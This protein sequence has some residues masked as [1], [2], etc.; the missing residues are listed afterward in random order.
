[1]KVF[2][3]IIILTNLFVQCLGQDD[4]ENINQIPITVFIDG[5]YIPY[6]STFNSYF[7]I[8]S[9][10]D[11]SVF[12]I[13]NG[14]IVLP[15]QSFSDSLLAIKLVWGGIVFNLDSINFGLFQRPYKTEWVFG[16]D[17]PPFNKRFNLYSGDKLAS[18]GR[19]IKAFKYWRIDPEGPY[20]SVTRFKFIYR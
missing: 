16:V 5:E 18:D 19:E 15:K 4:L 8:Y 20:K 2:L 6:D 11:T 7:S 9:V 17:Y 10:N 1:M 3:F 14:M 12:S 13:S